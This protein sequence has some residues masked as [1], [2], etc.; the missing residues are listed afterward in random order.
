MTK[1]L[2]IFSVALILIINNSLF[3]N[4]YSFSNNL[5]KNI[6][7]EI[8]QKGFNAMSAT[9]GANKTKIFQTPSTGCLEYVRYNDFKNSKMI[10]INTEKATSCVDV[11]FTITYKDEKSQEIIIQ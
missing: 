2:I 9:I 5:D 6:F 8:K 4:N 10:S 1:T 11:D 7:V 3:P